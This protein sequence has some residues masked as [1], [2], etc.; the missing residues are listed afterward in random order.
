MLL[1]R[2]VTKIKYNGWL[3]EGTI[4]RIL[5]GQNFLNVRLIFIKLRATSF[6]GQIFSHWII[7]F[8]VLF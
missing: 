8:R 3:H 4:T 1:L 5:V 2:S 7:R 6:I